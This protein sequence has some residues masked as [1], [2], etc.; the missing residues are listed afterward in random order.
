MKKIFKFIV[1]VF[2]L[3][4]GNL[5]SQQFASTGIEVNFGINSINPVATLNNVT[6]YMESDDFNSL[7]ISAGLYQ[8]NTNGSDSTTHSIAFYYSD[9]EELQKAY[10]SIEFDSHEDYGK[11][12]DAMM[13]SEFWPEF[14]KFINE[15]YPDIEYISTDIYYSM[16]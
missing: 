4:S 1:M 2:A 11:W 3:T 6:T 14:Q 13:E 8:V 9:T 10:Y 16:I 5:F 7:G 15:G 12:Q